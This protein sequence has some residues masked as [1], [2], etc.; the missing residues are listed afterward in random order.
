VAD[1]G[2]AKEK[3]IKI[4]AAMPVCG[5]I[6]PAHFSPRLRKQRSVAKSS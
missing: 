6:T 5:L 4:V 3:E 2:V 1:D